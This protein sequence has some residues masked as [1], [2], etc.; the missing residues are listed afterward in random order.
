MQISPP[1]SKGALY[2][3]PNRQN[4]DAEIEQIRAGFNEV[5]RADEVVGQALETLT[6]GPA[7]ADELRKNIFIELPPGTPQ[8]MHVRVRAP[9]PEVAAVMAH[10]IV[11]VRRRQMRKSLSGLPKTLK[12]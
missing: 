2:G 7:S 3:Q 5:L 11:E 8:F 4:G 10:L 9:D 6:L 12:P 1:S